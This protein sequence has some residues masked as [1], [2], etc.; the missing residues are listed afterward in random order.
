ML[1]ISLLVFWGC[2]QEIKDPNLM[3]QKEIHEGWTFRQANEGEWLPATVPGTV[4]TDLL[5]NGVI[6]DPYYRLNELD[7]QWIDKVDWEYKTTFTV[8]ENL[9]NRDRVQLDFKGLDTYADVYLNGEQILAANNM[10]REW[11]VDVKKLLNEGENEL[12]IRFRSP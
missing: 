6:D 4:H 12:H 3:I 11:Q 7:L 5:D 10:F 1:A 8:D 2:Q 9:L